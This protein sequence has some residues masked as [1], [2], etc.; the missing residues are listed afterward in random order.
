MGAA[1]ADMAIL[2]LETL[3]MKGVHHLQQFCLCNRHLN[4]FCLRIG[5]KL[6]IDS[7]FKKGAEVNRT[8]KLDL[9][10]VFKLDGI[11]LCQIIIM[12]SVLVFDIL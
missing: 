3:G 1:E 8:L 9:L 5:I 11:K 2:Q 7:I 4:L 6:E 10:A 12:F